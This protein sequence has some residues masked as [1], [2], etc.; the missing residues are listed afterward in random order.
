MK[1]TYDL[2]R[3]IAYLRLRPKGVEVETIRVSDG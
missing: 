2:R 1:L 3:N